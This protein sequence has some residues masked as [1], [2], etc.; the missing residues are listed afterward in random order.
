MITHFADWM[1][2][3]DIEPTDHMLK[4]RWGS[5]E[6]LD[7]PA[8]APDVPELVKMYRGRPG[9]PNFLTRFEAAFQ[10]PD[11]AFSLKSSAAAVRVLAGTALARIMTGN[12]NRGDLVALALDSSARWNFGEWSLPEVEA[13][14]QKRLKSRG[15][16]V[17]ATRLHPYGSEQEKSLK[18]AFSTVIAKWNGDPA[19][20]KEPWESLSG[21]MLKVLL[22]L[23]TAFSEAIKYQ[24]EE[25]DVLWWL[26]GAMSR[27][28]R[29]T[30]SEIGPRA[31][32]LVA[33]KELGDLT[34]VTPGLPS[35]IAFLQRAIELA[36]TRA[37][38][39]VALVDAVNSL[40]RGW[41]EEWANQSEIHLDDL[42]PA[43][44][45]LRSSVAVSPDDQWSPGFYHRSGIDPKRPW[46]TL[47][48]SEQFY[49]EL[50]MNREYAKL[51]QG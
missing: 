18:K 37:E 4:S 28:Q 23:S 6:A 46:P 10:S 33:A 5:I 19:T 7:K 45:A 13:M 12:D 29:R 30:F 50:L 26:F 21:Q 16:E 1:R 20:M 3:V 47:S 40:D 11:L 34:A 48:L 43:S 51:I 22:S 41:R 8:A 49:S 42:S 14:F 24:Q 27:D 31:I 36:G 15:R 35:S 9:S 32:P 38:A 25:T 44:L 2:L 17:R 39:P